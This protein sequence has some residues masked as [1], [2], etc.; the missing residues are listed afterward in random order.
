[1][2]ILL[3]LPVFLLLSATEGKDI[4]VYKSYED[5]APLLHQENDTTYVINFWATWCKPCVA[6]LPYFDQLAE[7]YKDEKVKVILV[8]MD[9]S[10]QIKARLKPFLKKKK[11][12]SEVVVFD[13][14]KP[15]QWIPKIDK[16]WS[17][18]I[19][20]TY[21]YRGKEQ[22]FYERSFEY[23]ELKEVVTPFL[24]K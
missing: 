21:I 3:L 8:S 17:G 14:P 5:F 15:N 6:E 9:F 19:P 10:D 22:A 11:V 4:P 24:T 2:R 7:E 1:M 23:E 16:D 20:A 13:A 18:A 12:A